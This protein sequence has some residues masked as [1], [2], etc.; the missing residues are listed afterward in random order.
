M[1]GGKSKIY[2]FINYVFLFELVTTIIQNNA[3]TAIIIDCFSTI[4]KYR[5]IHT[6]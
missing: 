1:F 5:V 6:Y 4:N 2:L 3:A